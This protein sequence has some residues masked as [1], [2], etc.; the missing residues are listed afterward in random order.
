M[1]FANDRF[2]CPSHMSGF[3][4]TSSGDIHDVGVSGTSSM[5]SLLRRSSNLRSTL[6]LSPKGSLRTCW[7]T[8][9]TSLLMCSLRR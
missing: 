1:T 7:A 2:V 5:M 3:G 4:A 8:S 6:S 9:L